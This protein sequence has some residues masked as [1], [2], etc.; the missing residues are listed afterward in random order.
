MRCGTGEVELHGE[1]LSADPAL[2]WKGKG[3]RNA[4]FTTDFDYR[5]GT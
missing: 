5:F 1:P 4:A 2:R 3:R